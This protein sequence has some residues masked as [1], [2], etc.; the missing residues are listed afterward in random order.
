MEKDFYKSRLQALGLE[1]IIPE[2]EDR[3]W[4]SET[5]Y[6]ELVLGKVRPEVSSRFRQILNQFSHPEVDGAIL[7]CTELTLLDLDGVHLRLFDT[8]RIHVE[9]AIDFATQP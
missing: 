9:A 5:I 6:S 4:I 7:G 1:V 3:K 2:A 8:A